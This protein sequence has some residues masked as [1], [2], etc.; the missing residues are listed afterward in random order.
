[1]V[2]F[3]TGNTHRKLSALVLF[4]HFLFLG[5]ILW[6]GDDL[7]KK[8]RDKP[9]VVRTVAVKPAIKKNVAPF[10]AQEKKGAGVEKKIV[11]A[12]PKVEVKKPPQQVLKKQEKLVKPLGKI[13]L[14]LLQEGRVAK[15]VD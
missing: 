4:S 10:V 12:E 13:E 5:Y 3:K 1:M 2:F 8:K 14:T 7:L 11:K 9:F 6:G 15:L